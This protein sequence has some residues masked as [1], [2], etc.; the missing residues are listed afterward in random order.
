MHTTDVTNYR[1]ARARIACMV[2][3]TVTFA[4]C[5]GGSLPSTAAPGSQTAESSESAA[6]TTAQGSQSAAPTMPPRAIVRVAGVPSTGA[7]PFYV[8]I[9]EGIFEKYNLEIEQVQSLSLVPSLIANE[10]DVGISP[11]ETGVLAAAQGQ[12]LPIFVMLSSRPNLSLNV[13]P[14]VPLPSKDLGYPKN[15]EDLRGMTVATTSIGGGGFTFIQQV[16]LGAGM[17]NGEDYDIIAVGAGENLLTALKSGQVDVS[18][19]YP[20]FTEM[21]RIQNLAVTL[22]DET[23]GEGPASLSKSGGV[24]LMTSPRFLRDQPDVLRRLVAAIEEATAF[25]RDEANKERLLEIMMEQL[26]IT[27][28]DVASAALE[29]TRTIAYPGVSCD[30]LTFTAQGLIDAGAI[31]TA[32][33]CSVMIATGIAPT[34]PTGR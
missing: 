13:S 34:E 4:G 25:V 12:P 27:D 2:I 6:P 26:A 23:K 8:A 29:T 11:S 17:V 22:V 1:T 16:F 31:Q 20:P 18:M 10:V 14:R 30:A 33:D 3:C 9:E 5:G 15:I 24:M 7:F 21:A 28:P 19:L 32:P